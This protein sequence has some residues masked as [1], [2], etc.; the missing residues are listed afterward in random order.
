MFKKF[1]N[2]KKIKI[3][4]NDYRFYLKCMLPEIV[5]PM[6]GIRLELTD[7]REPIH[8]QNNKNNKKLVVQKKK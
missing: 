3:M 7:I 8:I 1:L 6:Y 4:F 5:S 2:I